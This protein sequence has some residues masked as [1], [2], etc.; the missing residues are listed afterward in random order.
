MTRDPRKV[1]IAISLAASVL[2]L[3]GKLTAYYITHSAAMLADA[4]ESVVHGVATA[5]AAF[6]LWYAAQPADA[7][8]PYGHGRIVYFSTGAEGMLVVCASVAVVFSGIQRLAYGGAL[9]DLGW[10]IA[11]SGTLALINLALG[12]TLISVG[13]RHNAVVLIANGKHV[14]SDFRTTAGAIVGVGAVMLT[15]IEWLDPL[16]ALLIGAWI[17]VSGIALVRQS[18]G[19]LMDRVDPEISAQVTQ[20][21]EQAVAEGTIESFHKIRCRTINDEIFIDM[22]ILAQGKLPLAEAHDRATTVETALRACFPQ[23]RVHISS[24][25]EPEEHEAAHPGGYGDD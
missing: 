6:S 4:A 10:G 22:H 18:F 8:H 17:A 19:G 15:G 14:L 1:T 20:C 21:L 25:L 5:F 23:H 11:I 9:H 16:A 24:H 3:V 12:V 2:M 13:R 7:E